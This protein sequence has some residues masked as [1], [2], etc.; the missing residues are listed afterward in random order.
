MQAFNKY[1]R[2]AQDP[3][4]TVVQPALTITVS[5]ASGVLATAVCTAATF[6]TT[7]VG[8]VVWGGAVAGARNSAYGGGSVE[9]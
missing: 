5:L 9:D 4:G 1:V 7:A 8:G 3:W 2:I 6:G